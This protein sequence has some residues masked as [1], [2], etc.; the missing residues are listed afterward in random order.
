MLDEHEPRK[1]HIVRDA[2]YMD[3]KAYHDY[4]D[5][6]SIHFNWGDDGRSLRDYSIDEK[7]GS[8]VYDYLMGVSAA[9]PDG[10]HVQDIAWSV[11]NMFERLME[12]HKRESEDIAETNKLR[13]KIKRLETELYIQQSHEADY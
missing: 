3:D 5:G 8:T 6:E 10:H 13:A 1:Y 7:Y 12:S 9:L 4:K 2:D 11:R